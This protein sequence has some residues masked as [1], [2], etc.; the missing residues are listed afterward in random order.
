M[1]GRLHAREDTDHRLLQHHPHQSDEI[2]IIG[3]GEA[4][5]PQMKIFNRMLEID[6]GRFRPAAPKGRS[7]LASS[8]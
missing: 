2:E 8:S 4:T 6:D 1:D 3:V 5:I 7:S